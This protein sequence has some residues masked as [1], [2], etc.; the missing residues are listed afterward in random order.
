VIDLHELRFLG[1]DQQIQ[2]RLLTDF[3]PSAV[4]VAS[5]KAWLPETY[6]LVAQFIPHLGVQ[7]ERTVKSSAA[8]KTPWSG[9]QQV[10]QQASFEDRAKSA[11]F[12]HCP[13]P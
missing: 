1:G 13:P 8:V 5:W 7:S 3:P 11:K 4:Y 10:L 2:A 12:C 6:A 9:P